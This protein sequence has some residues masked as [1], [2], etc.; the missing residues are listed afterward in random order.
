MTGNELRDWRT[1]HGIT[2]ATLADAL[3]VDPQTISRW[4]RSECSIPPYLALAL[5]HIETRMVSL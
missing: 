1:S 4:E 3:H 2:Q 5:S